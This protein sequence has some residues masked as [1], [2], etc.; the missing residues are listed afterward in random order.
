MKNLILTA[1]FISAFLMSCANST[2]RVQGNDD[3]S[4]PD[5][6]ADENSDDLSDDL[7]DEVVTDSEDTEPDEQVN[8]EDT[9]I[10]GLD[11]GEPVAGQISILANGYDGAASEGYVTAAFYDSPVHFDAFSTYP[12]LHSEKAKTG[13]CAI[14]I[15]ENAACNPTCDFDEYCSK[16]SKCVR[17]PAMVSAGTV[18]VSANGQSFDLGFDEY[19]G[20]FSE[21]GIAGMN[22]E[23]DITV[24]VQGAT[25]EAF[26]SVIPTPPLILANI[27][28]FEVN[29]YDEEDTVITWEKSGN[30]DEIIYIV[31][32]FGWHGAPPEAVILCAAPDSDGSVTISKE[33]S[34]LA[35]LNGGAG[36]EPHGSYVMRINRKVIQANYGKILIRSGFNFYVNVKHE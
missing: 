1:I 11:L 19:F 33:I 36:L 18:N 5:E 10:G 8:D 26:E 24:K 35:P 3:I 22:S 32:N 4:V 20:Y 2:N 25:V 12:D 21:N 7:S 27:S 28:N 15:A 23:P 17:S 14:Y 31:L 9:S 13:K 29:L 16:D 34:K 30:A 6:T